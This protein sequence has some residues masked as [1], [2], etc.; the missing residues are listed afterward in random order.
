[1]RG[2]REFFSLR[3]CNN[4]LAIF[5]RVFVR[6]CPLY[7]VERDVLLSINVND[8]RNTVSMITF[9]AISYLFEPLV[10]FFDKSCEWYVVF[11]PRI[12]KITPFSEQS[13]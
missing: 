2:Q 9:S 13:R 8:S 5:S 12:I 6:E 4:F 1:M 10:T 7:D 3:L 11:E